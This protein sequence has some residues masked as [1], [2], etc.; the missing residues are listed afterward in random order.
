MPGALELV[1]LKS[2]SATSGEKLFLGEPHKDISKV[3]ALPSA[4]T[5]VKRQQ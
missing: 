1:T 5:A 4:D 2:S 3:T